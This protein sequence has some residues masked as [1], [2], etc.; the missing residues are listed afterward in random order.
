MTAEQAV[1]VLIYIRN[2]N[3]S[4]VDDMLL[5]CMQ[6]AVVNIDNSFIQTT[7]PG[8]GK[9][10]SLIQSGYGGTMQGSGVIQT[11]TDDT[12]ITG[13]HLLEPT[14]EGKDCLITYTVG[15]LEMHVNAKIESLSFQSNVGSLWKFSATFRFTSEIIRNSLYDLTNYYT[16]AGQTYRRVSTTTESTFTEATLAGLASGNY[17]RF[18]IAK[19]G[20]KLTTIIFPSDF[21]GTN[22]LEVIYYNDTGQFE[23][24]TSLVE[25]DVI[26]ILYY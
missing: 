23:F 16:V 22:P 3:V 26:L 10:D 9:V 13:T 14:L 25:G 8:T 20:I 7:Q 18:I 4:G 17:L 15:N 1:D 11:D 5:A 24:A 6:N 12:K 2:N 19:N 21:S